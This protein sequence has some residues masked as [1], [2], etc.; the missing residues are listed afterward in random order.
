[1]KARELAGRALDEAVPYTWTTLDYDQ[2]QELL[3]RHTELIVRECGMVILKSSRRPDDMAA[4]IVD[5]VNRHF[6]LTK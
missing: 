6:G 5:H 4:I 1:M 2:V 3:A